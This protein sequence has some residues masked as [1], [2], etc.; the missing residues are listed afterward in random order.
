MA[1]FQWEEPSVLIRA[2]P[3]V[4]GHVRFAQRAHSHLVLQARCSLNHQQGMPQTRA[5][6]KQVLC[7]PQQ[8]LRGQLNLPPLPL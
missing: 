7:T 3:G 1:F 4:G 2:Y 8:Q 5:E 6:G